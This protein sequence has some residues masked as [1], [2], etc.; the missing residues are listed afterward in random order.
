MKGHFRNLTLNINSKGSPK[1]LGCVLLQ[2]N[3]LESCK[4]SI[5]QSHTHVI[6]YMDNKNDF[7]KQSSA[8]S[9][10]FWESHCLLASFPGSYPKP[11]L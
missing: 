9:R 7:A 3:A 2:G 6:C 1:V 10:E 8:I 4:D 5:L 11:L